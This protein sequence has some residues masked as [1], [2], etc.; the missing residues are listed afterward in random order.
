MYSLLPSQ[1]DASK[2]MEI[3]FRS[4]FAFL[5]GVSARVNLFV[6]FPCLHKNDFHREWCE[7]EAYG[8]V[9]PSLSQILFH[10]LIFHEAS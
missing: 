10:C 2:L 5:T 6:D 3:R 9:D 8:C 1:Q 4:S 7:C